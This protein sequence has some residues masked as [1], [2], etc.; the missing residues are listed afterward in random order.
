MNKPISVQLLEP[1]AR[2][3]PGQPSPRFPPAGS[4]FIRDVVASVQQPLSA[5]T[6]DGYIVNRSGQVTRIFFKREFNVVQPEL[7]DGEIADALIRDQ[8]VIS[9]KQKL[10]GLAKKLNCGIDYL[11][12]PVGYPHIVTNPNKMLLV[13]VDDPS[14]GRA[15]RRFIQAEDLA[16][17]IQSYRGRSFSNPKPITVATSNIECF[18]AN[19]RLINNSADPFPGD[20]DFVLFDGDD[21]CSI[22]EFKTHNLDSDIAN[23]SC[24][25]YQDK[26]WRR[27]EVLLNVTAALRC[28]IFY[29]FWGPKHSH[30]KIE[31]I[32]R[33]RKILNVQIME[34]DAAHLAAFLSKNR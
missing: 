6:V 9:A 34:K 17:H 12:S 23:E 31:E 26:D 32:T 25:R 28:R 20:L 29:I 3:C 2:V 14:S 18:L 4:G 30:V 1:T 15:R 33:D 21:V 24:T 22:A 27:L 5:C 7:E 13:S 16:Q 10:A 19:D 11:F 8:S